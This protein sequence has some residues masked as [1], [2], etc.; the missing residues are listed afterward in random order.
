VDCG[1]RCKPIKPAPPVTRTF[2]QI[3]F[4]ILINVWKLKINIAFLQNVFMYL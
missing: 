1:T 3:L 2:L 4:I